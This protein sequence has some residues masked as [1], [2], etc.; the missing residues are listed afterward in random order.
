MERKGEKKIILV[1]DDD[2]KHLLTAKDLLEDMGYEVRMHQFAFGVTNVVRETQPDLILLDMNM[3]GLSGERL[4]KV[5]LLNE[6]TK[7]IPIVFYSSNDEDSLRRAVVEHG[8]KGYIAKGDI[9]DLRNKVAQYL[10]A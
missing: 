5:L 8:V 9:F 2:M 10:G 7:E 1:V 6:K 3:P 4:S